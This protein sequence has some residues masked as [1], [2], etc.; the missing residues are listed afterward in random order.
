MVATL[1]EAQQASLNEAIVQFEHN[2]SAELVIM[3]AEA[4]NDYT[5]V[6][7]VWSLIFASLC[8]WGLWWGHVLHSFPALWISQT[9][10]LA[11]SFLV[12]QEFKLSVML[13]P[14]TVQQ[15]RASFAATA[16]YSLHHITHTKGRSGVLLYLSLKERYAQILADHSVNQHVPEQTWDILL[17]PLL[18][19]IPTAGLVPAL[20][21]TIHQAAL[22]LAPYLPATTQDENE[23]SDAIVLM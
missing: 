10:M 14:R 3:I 21:D 5:D 2:T 12:I 11:F 23:L 19:A 6:A 8:T 22:T 9:V 15:K 17:Q 4:S 18:K 1:T 7:V 16:Y 20:K 13:A